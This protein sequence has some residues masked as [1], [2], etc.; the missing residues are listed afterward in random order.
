VALYH[1]FE[2]LIR[3]NA[4][5]YA[6]RVKWRLSAATR[7]LGHFGNVEDTNPLRV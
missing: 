4:D 3:V 7:T 5:W 2:K 6:R 1:L